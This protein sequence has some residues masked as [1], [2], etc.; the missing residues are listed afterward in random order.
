MHR[1]PLS[2]RPRTQAAWVFS[3]WWIASFIG[4]L[5]IWIGRNF[6]QLELEQFVYHLVNLPEVIKPMSWGFMVLS[7]LLV[8]G[9]PTLLAVGCNTLYAGP[10]VEISRCNFLPFHPISAKC[11]RGPS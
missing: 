4:F 8:F 1:I 5:N 10:S 2:D 3:S 9:V 7:G 11:S 6:G